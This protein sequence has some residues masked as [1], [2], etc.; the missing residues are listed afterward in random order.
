MPDASFQDLVLDASD[1]PALAG[2]WSFVLG[3]A[4]DAAGGNDR[5]IVPSPGGHPGE[6]IWV[7]EVPEP[8]TG[9]T[10]VHLDLRLPAPDPAP[11]VAAG[12]TLEHEPHDEQHWWVLSDPEGNGFCAMPPAPS[13]AGGPAR[14][15]RRGGGSP[16]TVGGASAS[17]RR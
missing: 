2:F 11:L 14:R 13:G 9:K 10:R 4:H 16:S 17:D 1:A 6:R 12:A 8:R 5:V 7:D 15:E 3:R